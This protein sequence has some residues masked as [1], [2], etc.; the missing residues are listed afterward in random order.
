[1]KPRDLKKLFRVAKLAYEA[2]VKLDKR[3]MYA[4]FVTK[5]GHPYCCIVI[6][7]GVRGAQ[8]TEFFET[9]LKDEAPA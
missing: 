5:D 8:L 3:S 7:R 9:T 6:A 1:M 4:N 2:M